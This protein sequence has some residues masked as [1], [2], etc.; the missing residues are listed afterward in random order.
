MSQKQSDKEKTGAKEDE[1]KVLTLFNAPD[2]I[3]KA[4]E[5]DEEV[6]K[7][8]KHMITVMRKDFRTVGRKVD[9]MKKNL[10][11]TQ[12]NVVNLPNR[13]KR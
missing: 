7:S 8:L 9:A 2:N 11:R 13:L 12:Q 4:E 5:Y 10:N 6:E 3:S 1:K